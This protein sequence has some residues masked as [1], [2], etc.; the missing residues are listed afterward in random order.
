MYVDFKQFNCIG[1]LGGTFNPIHVGHMMMAKE[2]YNQ[3]PEIE[4]IIFIPNNKTAYKDNDDLAENKHR[5]KML[6]LSIADIDFAMISDIEINRGGI[7]FTYDT[8]HQIKNMSSQTEIFFIIGADSLYS[9]D[10]WYR[11]EDILKMCT[12]LVINR[13]SSLEKLKIKSEKF[14]NHYGAS[15][16]ILNTN[17]VDVSSTDIRNRIKNGDSIDNYVSESVK[18]YIIKQ[19]LYK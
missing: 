13:E 5:L 6:E 12:L 15:I 9:F 1:I 7:T 10:K 3:V 17:N 2:A 14:I 11:F 4:K 8:L 19:N 16:K 18:K